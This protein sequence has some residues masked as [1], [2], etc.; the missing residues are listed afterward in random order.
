VVGVMDKAA[1]VK[2]VSNAKAIVDEALPWQPNWDGPDL[3][4]LRKVALRTALLE[5]L[6]TESASRD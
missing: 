5:I 1:Y 4:E 2:A 6:S 3:T